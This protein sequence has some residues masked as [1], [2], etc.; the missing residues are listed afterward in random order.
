M[1]AAADHISLGGRPLLMLA[2]G[3]YYGD[4][5]VRDHSILR[6]LPGETSSIVT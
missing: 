4:S 5:M 6:N 2:G 1:A 3:I